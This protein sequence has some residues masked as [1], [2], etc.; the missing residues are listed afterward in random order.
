MQNGYQ[1]V[2]NAVSKNIRKN[3]AKI[4]YGTQVYLVNAAQ[5]KGGGRQ[6]GSTQSRA[7]A[8]NN[9][10]QYGTPSALRN[11]RT[12]GGSTVPRPSLRSYGQALGQ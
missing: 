12:S 8:D 5:K 1:R 3:K 2:A 11:M 9:N 4:K 6:K 10:M 7:G